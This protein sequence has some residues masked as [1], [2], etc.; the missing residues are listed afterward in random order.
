MIEVALSQE[1]VRN[2]ER[3]TGTVTWRAEGSKTPRKLEL[4]CRWRTEGKG[5]KHQEVIADEAH[6]E[7]EGRSEAVVSFDF[8]IPLEGPISYD[9]KL[10][11][12][13]WEMV[14][15]VDLPLA[16]D[17]HD[18]KAFTVVPRKWNAQEWGE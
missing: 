11:R 9:G 12:I 6:T 5:D 4:I 3:V 14:A 8:P 10:L 15:N 17:E 18:V 2:G 1:K 16:R 13:V 7:L